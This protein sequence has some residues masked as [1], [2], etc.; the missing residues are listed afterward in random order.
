[1]KGKQPVLS[2]VP[3]TLFCALVSTVS[4]C[5]DFCAPAL[6]DYLDCVDVRFVTGIVAGKQGCIRFNQ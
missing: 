1:V 5:H 4:G 3:L 2:K 6:D